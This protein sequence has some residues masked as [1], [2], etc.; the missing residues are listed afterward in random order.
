[1]SF[2]KFMACTN[3]YRSA[4]IGVEHGRELRDNAVSLH[5]HDAVVSETFV[6]FRLPF[7]FRRFAFC[8]AL[9]CLVKCFQDPQYPRMAAD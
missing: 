2:V 5:I 1:M 8:F 7:S 3:A 4:G 6:R 9:F